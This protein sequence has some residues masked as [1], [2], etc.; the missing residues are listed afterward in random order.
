ML[1]V[2]GSQTPPRSR[3]EIDALATVPGM[4]SVRLPQGKLALHEE[5]P[6]AVAQAIRPFLAEGE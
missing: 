2:Y 4:R 5:F 1:T 3:A 6:D